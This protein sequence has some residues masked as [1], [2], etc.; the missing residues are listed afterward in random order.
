MI[1]TCV[2]YHI[3]HFDCIIIAISRIYRYYETVND[4]ATVRLKT[5]KKRYDNWYPFTK[6]RGLK[7]YIL[8]K[9]CDTCILLLFFLTRCPF[10]GQQKQGVS[11]LLREADLREVH[12]G[13]APPSP[14]MTCGFLKYVVFLKKKKTR[15]DDT[16]PPLQNPGSALASEP[17][18]L[19]KMAN[20]T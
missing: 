3:L 18:V 6:Q 20:F 17:F 2:L 12:R 8:C 15:H 9:N 5:C 7:V 14:T 11:R 1:L 10:K 4:R 16:P 19:I 13:F